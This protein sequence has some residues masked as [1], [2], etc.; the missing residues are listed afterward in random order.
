MLAN[1]NNFNGF[2]ATPINTP[3]IGSSPSEKSPKKKPNIKN[4]V[5]LIVLGI[6]IVLVIAVVVFLILNATK[7]SD[8]NN[9][10]PASSEATEALAQPEYTKTSE[11]EATTRQILDEYISVEI[12]DVVVVED[13]HGTND[14]V[15]VTVHNKSDK[16]ASIAIMISAKDAD[17]NIMDIAS[18]YAEGIGPGQTQVFNA[19]QLSELTAEQ[20][21]SAKYEVHKANT[22]TVPGEEGTEETPTEN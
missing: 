16:S 7:N 15:E 4:P 1:N 13:E 18:L 14:A 17:G 22:Y 8:N 21:K 3:I 6:I 11:D 9:N 19:F 20:L 2:D 10:E 12:G 5:V